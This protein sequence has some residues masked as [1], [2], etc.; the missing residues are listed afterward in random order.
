MEFCVIRQVGNYSMNKTIGNTEI[1]YGSVIVWQNQQ[2]LY[3]QL[4]L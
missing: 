4:Q 3:F 1:K 2:T